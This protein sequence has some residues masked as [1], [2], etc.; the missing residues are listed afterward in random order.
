MKETSQ[1]DVD[2]GKEWN[3]RQ[4]SGTETVNRMK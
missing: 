2:K 1:G 4:V 3:H